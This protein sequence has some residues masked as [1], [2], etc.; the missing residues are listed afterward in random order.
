MKNANFT[1]CD[2]TVHPGESVTFA[3]PL[4]DVFSCAQMYMPIRIIHGKQRGPCLV[5]TAAMHGDEVN[6]TEIINRLLDQKAIKSLKGTLITV[7][8]L[9]VFAFINKSRYL[10][11]GTLLDDFFPGSDTGNRA[12]RLAHLFTTEVLTHADYCID[13]QTGCLNQSNLPQIHIDNNHPKEVELAQAFGTP[14]INQINEESGSLRQTADDMDIPFLVYEAGEAMRFDEQAIK[15]GVTGLLNI[16]RHIE[17]LPKPQKK[18]SKKS[19]SFFVKGSEWL[20]SPCSGIC[21]TEVVLG[22]QV[23]NGEKIGVIKDPF[24]ANA[25]AKITAPADGVVVGMN[26]LPLVEEGADLFEVACF[27]QLSKAASHLESWQD[28]TEKRLKDID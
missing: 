27:E 15:L 13:L 25:P 24:G 8:I 7:P 6:G 1:I 3:L 18:R 19:P 12:E 21:Q 17:M 9:N 14:V 2:Q 26:N 16:M 22:Q 20:R 4:P 10:P 11:N 28:K 23:A 5:V